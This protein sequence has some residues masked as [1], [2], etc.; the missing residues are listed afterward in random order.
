MGGF[1]VSREKM[2]KKREKE[3]KLKRMIKGK[4]CRGSHAKPPSSTT[5]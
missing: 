4:T 1:R 2:E 3:K 5:R